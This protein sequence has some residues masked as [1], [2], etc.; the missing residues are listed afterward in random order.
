MKTLATILNILGAL[1]LLLYPFVVLANLMSLAGHRNG[2]ESKLLITVVYAFLF[3]SLAYP[4]VYLVC[5]ALSIGSMRRPD[6]N[7]PVRFA[8]A[9][10]A[11]LAFLGFLMAAAGALGG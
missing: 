9:P 8:A 11:Y 4:L 6:E 10:L 7:A 1:P 3:G 2:T 5:R